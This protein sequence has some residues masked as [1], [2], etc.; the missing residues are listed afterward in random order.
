MAVPA[1]IVA[2]GVA[3]HMLLGDIGLT[4]TFLAV[5]PAFWFGRGK[6]LRHLLLLSWL[7]VTLEKIAEIQMATIV[8]SMTVLDLMIAGA[9][10]VVAT[11]DH[12]RYDARVIGSISMALM[13]G[14]WVMAA[15]QGAGSWTLYA[16]AV[17][18]GFVLQCLV[19]GGWLDG[20]GRSIGRLFARLRPVHLFRRGRG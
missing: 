16:A 14:H 13:P 12:A 4:V 18:A 2:L 11:H 19:I 15:T 17:N 7:T 9:A 20:V 3:V 5:A 8:F 6:W 10:L 1:M